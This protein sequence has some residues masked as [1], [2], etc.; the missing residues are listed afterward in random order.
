MINAEPTAKLTGVWRKTSKY[1]DFF[2]SSNVPKAEVLKLLE[3][4]PGDSVQIYVEEVRQKTSDRSPDFNV[5]I[6][7]AYIKPE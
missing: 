7:P 6:K 3:A 1:G 4:C 2:S 5:K